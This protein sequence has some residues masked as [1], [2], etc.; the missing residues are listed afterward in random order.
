MLFFTGANDH[1]NIYV[2]DG[3]FYDAGNN[4]AIHAV[5][6]IQYSLGSNFTYAFRQP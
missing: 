6:P 4:N 2:G 1:T 3:C 5:E